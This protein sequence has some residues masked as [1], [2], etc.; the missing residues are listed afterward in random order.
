M[1]IG[2]LVS[3]INIIYNLILNFPGNEIFNCVSPYHP[4]KKEYYTS[5]AIA[6][7][8]KLPDFDHSGS[9]TRIVSSKKIINSALLKFKNEVKSRKY[10]TKKYSY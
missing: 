4:T 3:L 6:K 9:I 1:Q 5:V 2:L 7:N 8:L 10:P